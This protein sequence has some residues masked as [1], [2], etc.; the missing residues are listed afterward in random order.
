MKKLLLI[1]AFSSIYFIFGCTETT[2]VAGPESTSIEESMPIPVSK[3]NWLTLP[4]SDK[5]ALNKQFKKGKYI[6][7]KGGRGNN[8]SINEKYDGGPFG[9]VHVKAKIEFR[10]Q[11]FNEDS[12]YENVD[13]KF[14]NGKKKLWFTLTVDDET[15][16]AVFTPHIMFDEPIKCNLKFVGLDLSGFDTDNIKFVFIPE[17]SESAF[18]PEYEDLIVDVDKGSITVINAMIP[19]F[20]RYGLCN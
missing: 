8:I 15:C 6:K 11:N 5:M 10:K 2:Q 16:S 3:V 18:V 12:F 17:G 4:K 7:L 19:H 13:Y 9:E 14:K 20:S 1:I